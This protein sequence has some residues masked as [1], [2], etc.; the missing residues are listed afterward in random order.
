MPMIFWISVLIAVVFAYSTIKLGFYHAW[1]MMFNL[2]VAVYMAVR[3]GPFVQ[4]FFPAAIDGQYSKALALLA[5]GTGTFLILQGIAYVLLI[6]QFEVTF[7]RAMNI[8]GSGLMGFLAGLLVCSFAMLVICTT[9]LCQKQSVKEIGL[10]AKNFEEAKMQSC[11]VKTCNFMDIFVGSNDNHVPVE[12]TIK[13]LL[14]IP[15]KNIPKDA[16]TAGVSQQPK[17]ADVTESD[18]TANPPAQDT[19]NLVHP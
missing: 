1:T 6:G 12:K 13:E 16:N 14:L 17:P 18:R 2:L 8:L 4:D 11:L 3:I 5:T 7:P 19:N 9:P 15:V 10:D